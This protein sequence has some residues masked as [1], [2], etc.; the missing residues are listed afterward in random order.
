M[1][2][3]RAVPLQG[4]SP[5]VVVL[6]DDFTYAISRYKVRARP[7]TNTVQRGSEVRHGSRGSPHPGR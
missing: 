1:A 2:R 3:N 6:A 4:S 7:A 5:G